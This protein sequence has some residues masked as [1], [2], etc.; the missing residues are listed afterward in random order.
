MERPALFVGDADGEETLSEEE[1]RSFQLSF[2]C[3]VV[4]EVHLGAFFIV[5]L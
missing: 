3:H 2:Q 1:V 4:L 5:R